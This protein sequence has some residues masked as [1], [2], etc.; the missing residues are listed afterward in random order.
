MASAYEQYLQREMEKSNKGV[1][2]EQQREVKAGLEPEMTTH[3]VPYTPHPTAGIMPPEFTKETA[4]PKSWWGKAKDLFHTATRYI[5][6]ELVMGVAN[7]ANRSGYVKGNLAKD[8]LG[9]A[10]FL[11]NV[12]N[13]D[14]QKLAGVISA[15]P[16][17][18]G[19]YHR[20]KEI[21]GKAPEV[22][23]HI[24]ERYVSSKPKKMYGEGGTGRAPLRVPGTSTAI[25]PH[26]PMANVRSS[27]GRVR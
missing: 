3:I 11:K 26:N 18:V 10:N 12:K 13:P 25:V 16:A 7:L 15:I 9:V 4:K 21:A 23:E 5:T 20:G 22:I 14:A 2:T 27:L 19:L 17:G 24:K 8:A 6:P 1:E